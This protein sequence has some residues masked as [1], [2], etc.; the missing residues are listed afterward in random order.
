MPTRRDRPARWSHARVPR[1]RLSERTGERFIATPLAESM[2]RAWRSHAVEGLKPAESSLSLL[3]R[4]ALPSSPRSPL[5]YRT[6]GRITFRGA[7]PR[8][9]RLHPR[10]HPSPESCS[11]ISRDSRVSPPRPGARTPPARC[12]PRSD[13]VS[14]RA[15]RLSAF[16]GISSDGPR[17]RRHVLHAARAPTSLSSRWYRCAEPGGCGRLPIRV[18][19]RGDRRRDA[20]ALHSTRYCVV[21]RTAAVASCRSP[22]TGPVSHR[23][24]AAVSEQGL[25]R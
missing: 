21:A 16:Q 14:S 10:S 13:P 7:A 19:R 8:A 20:Q 6:R 11:P 24:A 2:S 18:P 17:C 23:V 3:L 1:Q 22:R 15:D 9:P 4:H 12:H 25:S 5:R